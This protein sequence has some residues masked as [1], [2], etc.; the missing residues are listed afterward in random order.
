MLLGVL[1]AAST[2]P[3]ALIRVWINDHTIKATERTTE[4]TEQGLITDRITATVTGLGAEKTFGTKPVK[5]ATKDAPA[6]EYTEPNLEVRLGAAYALE[7][8]AQDSESARKIYRA[9]KTTRRYSSRADG[10][11]SRRAGYRWKFCAGKALAKSVC[12]RSIHRHKF[13]PRTP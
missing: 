4:A 7:H 2:V 1:V 5:T 8:I 11:Q 9:K 12:G 3:F 6:T 10:D 13:Q